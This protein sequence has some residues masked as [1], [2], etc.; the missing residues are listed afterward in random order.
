MEPMTIRIQDETKESLEEAASEYGV[1]VS[2]YVRELIQQGR[3]YDDLRDRLESREARIEELEEELAKRSQVEEK[4]D[5]L[6]KRNSEPEPP[7]FVS[8]YQYFTG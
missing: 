5:T 3:E 4:V 7:F 8:W 2:E 6:V 1:S